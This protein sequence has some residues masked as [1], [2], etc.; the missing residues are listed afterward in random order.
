[1]VTGTDIGIVV[2]NLNSSQMHLLS[3]KNTRERYK[4]IFSLQCVIYIRMGSLI[5]IGN[6]SKDNSEFKT[7][8]E[9]CKFTFL[10]V[11]GGGMYF[12]F[13]EVVTLCFLGGFF[14]LFEVFCTFEG[15]F[16]VGVF[17]GLLYFWGIL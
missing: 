15:I 12:V 11:C 6:Q 17:S 8:F 5:L 2:S 7:K 14:V 16:L 4:S 13:E 3:H 10:C 9:V 1:M